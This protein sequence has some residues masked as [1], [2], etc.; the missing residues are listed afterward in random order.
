MNDLIY[1][2]DSVAI[3]DDDQSFKSA[4]ESPA[5]YESF[6][7]Y[8]LCVPKNNV[9]VGDDEAFQIE[10]DSNHS[11]FEDAM[12]NHNEEAGDGLIIAHAQNK[13]MNETD[14]CHQHSVANMNQKEID[15]NHLMRKAWSEHMQQLV[16]QSVVIPWL[17]QVHKPF[18]CIW[19]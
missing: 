12:S 2:D 6:M 9:K 18:I 7:T 8:S 4:L 15:G 16:H 10:F 13:N 11:D 17:P 19:K 5:I 3:S 14:T 1:D